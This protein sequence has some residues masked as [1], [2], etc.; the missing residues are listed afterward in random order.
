MVKAIVSV[1]ALAAIAAAAAIF[2]AGPGTKAGLWDNGTGLGLFRSLGLPAIVLAVLSAGGAVAAVMRA[3]ALAPLALVGAFAAA[4]AAYVP[5]E[6]KRRVD[7]NPF[8]HDVTTDV[9]DPPAIVAGAEAP[10]KN[11]PEYV[12][13][14]P[15]PRA[16]EGVSVADAQAAAFPDIRPM[17]FDVDLETAADAAR[18]VI[19]HMGLEMIA[20]GPVSDAP[21]SGWRIEAVAT[22]RWFGFKDDFVVRLAPQ[23]EGGGSESGGPGG[24]VRVDARSKSRVG[25]SDL[26][27]NAARIREFS[28][29]LRAAI[30]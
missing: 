10:R 11:P 13:A 5:S 27:A 28:R 12:G 26:G 16:D 9:D 17:F 7:E 21:G 8:I 2:A 6:M 4:A 24:G 25:G 20:E 23:S 18:D 22:S 30:G 1:L 19:V 14:E 3:R 29:Q 15:A